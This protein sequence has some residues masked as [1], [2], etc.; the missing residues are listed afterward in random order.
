MLRRPAAI[1]GKV[2]PVIC[3]ADGGFVHGILDGVR[4]SSRGYRL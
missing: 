1:T 3:L 2:V 4:S